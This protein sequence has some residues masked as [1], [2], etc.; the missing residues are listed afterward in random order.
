MSSRSHGSR[1]TQS[2]AAVSPTVAGPGVCHVPYLGNAAVSSGD[3]RHSPREHAVPGGARQAA[4]SSAP[5]PGASS[6][7]WGTLMGS[8]PTENP[9]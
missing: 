9:F 7:V 6:C 5:F 4:W 2:W 3:T 8:S 1:Y